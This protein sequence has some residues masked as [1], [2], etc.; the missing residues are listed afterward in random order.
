MKRC[1]L[2]LQKYENEI[3]KLLEK[4][5]FVFNNQFIGIK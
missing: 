3:W 4:Y 1:I 5:F 2:Q